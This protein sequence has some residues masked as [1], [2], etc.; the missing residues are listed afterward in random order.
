[1][2]VLPLL[3]GTLA[4]FLQAPLMIIGG[5]LGWFGGAGDRSFGFALFIAVV[6]PLFLM[7][8][9]YSALQPF[10]SFAG[11]TEIGFTRNTMPAILVGIA[12]GS[13]IATL[14]LFYPFVKA[15]RMWRKVKPV[16]TAELST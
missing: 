3:A 4:G 14:F 5:L 10:S 15:R 16:L 1:M 9:S 13:V 12:G 8:L 7:Y 2:M 6:V 11:L